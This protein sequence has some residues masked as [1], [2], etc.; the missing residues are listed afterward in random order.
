DARRRRLQ[1]PHHPQPQP[2]VA[3]RRLG[4]ADALG[5][6]GGHAAQRLGRLD[7]RAPDVAATVADQQPVPAAGP[8][9]LDAAVVELD[10]L[11]GVQLVEDQALARAGE[12]H[13]PDLDR[14]QPVD[15]EVGRQPLAVVD[16][17]VGDVLD[18]RVG[19]GAPPGGD[20]PGRGPQD[21]VDDRQVV[22]RQV[23]DDVHVVLE[24]AEVNAH[25][26]DVVQ[27]AQ[28][29]A[30]DHLLDQADGPRRRSTYGGGLVSPSGL[31]T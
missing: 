5:E 22:R 11:G 12:D 21:V 13:L 20:A 6:V 27:F 28:L 16:V 29:A 18:G 26:V 8:V 31:A 25:A 24:Q 2:P 15:V 23:P 19:G 30:V 10:R 4:G 9:H 1:Q 7:V 17:D 3:Q 14:R